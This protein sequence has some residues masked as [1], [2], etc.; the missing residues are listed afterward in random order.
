[1]SEAGGLLYIVDCDDDYNNFEPSQPWQ[2]ELTALMKQAQALRG[3]TRVLGSSLLK[4]LQEG[5]FWPEGSQVLY[6]STEILG[7]ERWKE[8]F[9]PEG[10]GMAGRDLQQLA[11]SGAI[12]LSRLA[13]LADAMRQFFKLSGIRAQ[14]STWHAWARKR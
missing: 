3:G 12:D 13:S 1:M 9:M 5:G 6:Y 14:I 4:I 8:I 10:G 2:A 7:L 11:K